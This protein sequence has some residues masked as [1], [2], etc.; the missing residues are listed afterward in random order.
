MR[1]TKIIKIC[2]SSLCTCLHH[3]VIL[4]TRN[5][6][7]DFL[8]ILAWASPFNVSG[9]SNQPFKAWIYH[10]HLH[11]LQA[12]NCCRNSRLVVS[13]DDFKWVA[14]EKNVLLL[15][16]QFREYVRSKPPSFKEIKLFFRHAKRC[17]DASWG[18]ERLKGW[19]WG[20]KGHKNIP[21]WYVMAIWSM[22]K[23]KL[24]D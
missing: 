22:V 14:K 16:N 23:Q 24:I 20:L 5:K 18:L 3:M 10:C 19:W 21:L 12:A 2:S 11:S 7:T 1:S 15:L 8:M 4:R 17:F 9:P 13:E 6:I